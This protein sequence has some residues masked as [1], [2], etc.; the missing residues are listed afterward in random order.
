VPNVRLNFGR[1]L[2]SRMK[3]LTGEH[4]E[5]RVASKCRLV[6]VV[7]SKHSFE[8]GTGKL[9]KIASVY[10]IRTK[11]ISKLVKF[12]QKLQILHASAF[13]NRLRAGL[14][15]IQDVNKSKD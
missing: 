5:R 3:R 4:T 10:R 14:V 15:L 1:M 7:A 6:N 11:E 8:I 13:K 12:K 9:C 2:Y